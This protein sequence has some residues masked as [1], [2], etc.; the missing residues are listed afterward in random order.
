MILITSLGRSGASVEELDDL[1]HQRWAIEENYKLRKGLYLN[2]RQMHSM[3]V[4]GV[5][6]EIIALH[7]F[8]SL[9]QA[10]RRLAARQ[11]GINHHD[12]S[13]KAAILATGR[14]MSGLA[15]A[16]DH[17]LSA[18]SDVVARTLAR[19]GRAIDARRPGRSYPRRSF[20]PQRRWS[21]AGRIGHI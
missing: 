21:P 15:L 3:S 9:A 11:V 13:Q 6:Q 12:L 20:Q 4:D 2:Q 8:T 18:W 17:S 5:E 1:Y 7:L 10:M 14:F 16:L 19:I